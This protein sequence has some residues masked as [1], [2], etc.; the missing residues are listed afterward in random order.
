MLAIASKGLIISFGTGCEP[1][2]QRLAD[3][4][5]VDIRYYNVIYNLV[6]DVAKALKGMLEPTY[7]EVIDGC[8]EVRAIFPSSKK[9]T[10]AGVYI[11]D[12]KL[13]RGALVRVKRQEQVVH[14]STVSSLRRFKNDVREVTTGYECGVGIEGFDDFQVGDILES[15]RREKTAQR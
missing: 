7:V 1:G 15:F 6:D 5:G 8:A 13:S 9:Q 11:N 3:I 2:A 10:V 14:E 12:G 4:Q